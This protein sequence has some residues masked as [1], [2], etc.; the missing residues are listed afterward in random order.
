MIFLYD[1]AET[2]FQDNGIGALSDAVSCIVT[3]ERNGIFDLEMKYPI[4]GIHYSS[5]QYRNIIFSKP[6]PFD[7]F[8]PFRIY[9]ITRPSNGVV[10]VYA[11][12]IS[13][14]LN[15]IPVTPFHTYTIQ[16]TLSALSTNAAIQ[17]NFTYSTDKSLSMAGEVQ[18]DVPLSARYILGG[19]E[20]SV[21]QTYRGEYKY[22]MF[23]VAL[24][25]NRGSNNGVV[26]RYGK[27]IIDIEQDEDYSNLYT[28]VA[29]FWRGEDTTVYLSD[30]I[31][32]VPG[33]FGFERILSLDMSDKFE[34]A[35]SEAE[36]RAAAQSY[37]SNNNIGVPTASVKIDYTMDDTIEQVHLC[38]TVSAIY[39]D[40]GIQASAKC[41]QTVYNELLNRYDSITLGQIRSNLAD[42]YAANTQNLTRRIQRIEADYA[43]NGEIREIAQEEI[44]NDTS[45]IQRAEAIIASALEEYVR[46]SDYNTFRASILTNISVLAGEIETGFTSVANEIS[47]LDGETKQSFANIYSFIRLLATITDQ[48]GTVTQEG[49]IV[50]GESSSDIKLKLENDVLYFF[51]GDEKLVTSANAIAWFK[52]NQLYV[53]NTTIQNLTLGT[54]GAY[55]DARIVGSGDNRCVL[56]SGRLS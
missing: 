7:G 53:N 49:G 8:Q 27:N 35:P 16:G 1:A 9:R 52:S 2:T 39:M 23:D 21:L 13:Y 37:I 17:N 20:G 5:L 29:P 31:E 33:T 45:I 55:L 32:F 42:T 46:T 18:T 28:G 44:T 38:D 12:H 30:T 56:W 43:T 25:T 4:T 11:H 40:L 41:V 36:L 6:N 34:T 51:T 50:I 26:L 15:G 22:N 14:D 19:M 54:T 3:E 47:T 10:T 24:L 48:Y